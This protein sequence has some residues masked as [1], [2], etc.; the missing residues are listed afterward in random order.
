MEEEVELEEL[1]VDQLDADYYLL[2]FSELELYDILVKEDEWSPHDVELARKLLVEKNFTI[3]ED[4]LQMQRSARMAEFRKPDKHQG[5]LIV[6]GYI[7]AF[8][9]GFLG[10]LFGFALLFTKKEIP[11]GDK[12]YRYTESNRKHGKI[13]LIISSITFSIALLTKLIILE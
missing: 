6:V 5:T 10:L 13:I 2:S 12:V 3:E 1:H 8:V 11:G 7:F 9:G 4:A